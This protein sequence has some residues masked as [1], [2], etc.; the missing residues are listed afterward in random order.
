MNLLKNKKRILVIRLSS[1]G[2]ILLTTPLLRY[3]HN[4][5]P[6]IEIDFL[7][8]EHFFSAVQFN[9]YVNKIF[10]LSDSKIPSILIQLKNSGYDLIIDLQNSFLSR[11][12]TKSINIRKKRFMKNSFNKFLLVNFKLNLFKSITPIAQRYINTISEKILPESELIPE[13]FY[14]D[15]YNSIANELIN[16]C[17]LNKVIGIC[18]GSKHFTKIYPK[19][20]F[21]KLID[22]LIKNDYSVFLFGGESEKI[23]CSELKIT[24][25]VFN[26]QNSND[27]FLTAALMSKCDAIITNDSSLMHIANSLNKPITALFGSSVKEWGFS[28]IGVPN[29]VLEINQLKCRPCSHFGKSFCPKK[30]FRCMNNI[31]P[32]LIF[33][34]TKKLLKI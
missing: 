30:H 27:L 18:P 21:I 5:Y 12:I 4:V 10:S 3:L 28:P 17:I 8:R 2:D 6:S 19:E 15:E 16:N 13:L 24:D 14:P 31:S 1:L 7:L 26:F 33:N 23:L 11:R 32:E 29:V 22:L 25:N 34:E 20:L 9:P